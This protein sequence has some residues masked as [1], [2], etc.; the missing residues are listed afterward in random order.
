VNMDTMAPA[1][2]FSVTNLAQ[3]AQ[4][5]TT[6]VGTEPLEEAVWE[7][8]NIPEGYYDVVLYLHPFHRYRPEV[9]YFFNGREITFRS[10][11]AFGDVQDN[12][13]PFLSPWTKELIRRDTAILPGTENE[14]FRLP[15]RLSPYPMADK[16]RLSPAQRIVVGSDGTLEVR[17]V[18]AEP[19]GG[20][21]SGDLYATSFDRLE[22]ISP[23]T[24]YVELVNLS[25]EDIDLSGWTI[26]TPYGHYL[27]PEDT[28][29]GRMKPSYE[30]DDGRELPTNKGLPG[31]GVP[32]EPLLKKS[33][34]T[35]PGGTINSTDLLLEDNKILLA[36]HKNA[37]IEFIKDNYPSVPD[38]D[39][40]VVEVTLAPKEQAM[41]IRSLSTKSEPMGSGEL[42]NAQQSDMRLRLVDV[43]EDILTHNPA[44][45][46]VT[47]SDPS[48]HYVDS[49]KYRTTFNNV[50]VDIPGNSVS[51]DLVVLPGY[52]GMESFERSDPTYFETEISVDNQSGRLSGNRSVPSSIRLDAQDAIVLNLDSTKNL[53]RTHIGGYVNPSQGS[54]ND[55]RHPQ[56]NLPRFVDQNSFPLK[57][58]H[59]NGWDFIGDYYEYPD[60]NPEIAQLEVYESRHIYAREA[61][62]PDTPEK[63][64]FYDMLGGFENALNVRTTAQVRYSAFL[65]R[66]GLRELIRSGYDP[67]VDD[68]LTVR[69][70][71]R[72]AVNPDGE[73]GMVDLPVGEVMVI[74]VYRFVDPGD[75][76][77]DEEPGLE[78]NPYHIVTSMIRSNRMKQPV[79][80]KLRN[81]DTAFTIDLR[82]KFNDLSQDLKSSSESEPMIEIMVVIRKSTIDHGGG[83]TAN[84]TSAMRPD[85]EGALSTVG[86]A[87]A[88]DAQGN[89]W[90]GGNYIGNLSDDNYFFRGIELFGRGRKNRDD[91]EEANQRRQL[92]A[93]TPGRDNTGYVPA[94][95]RRRLELNGSQRDELDILDNTAYVK[96]GPL[97]TVGELS[98]LFTGNRFETINTPLIPQRLE[99]ISTGVNNRSYTTYELNKRAK[100]SE[101]EF[102]IALAQ[103]E[104]L[105]QWENQYLQLFN[106]ITTADMGIRMGL[107]NINTAPREVLMALPFCP[108]AAD[109][110]LESLIDRSNFNSVCADFIL[111]GRQ[112]VGFDMQFGIHSL[113]DDDFIS[114]VS[115]IQTLADTVYDYKIR[116]VGRE[117]DSFKN[118]DD[119][120]NERFDGLNLTIENIEGDR[121]GN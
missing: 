92:L 40:R 17:I 28:V 43:Q 26:D 16:Y 109:G 31:D 104:R 22:L 95:P 53:A 18:A 5:D 82:K 3:P 66:L 10:D 108:P 2:I 91:S 117:Y 4:S 58:A 24:Q 38:I 35:D 67:D 48:G 47:L 112:P 20:P 54:E 49:F 71:G 81:G 107:I 1:F 11:F 19:I 39:D 101:P 96:N 110:K 119:I 63:V 113:N 76:D 44:E 85:L 50:M 52:R 97:A 88:P 42:L 46:Y 14:S 79:F 15:Y 37:L 74:P 70:L 68:Q 25:T 73:F 6:L 83:A 61:V 60:D 86:G 36:N 45:K 90:F 121:P 33:K 115:G 7:F 64:W 29:I 118:F 72:Q 106:M 93:G 84:I 99:D 27:I 23:W 77:L 34:L 114:R 57:D 102:Q 8:N 30:D 105:D 98:R 100:S 12:T 116:S 120:E 94:Y 87:L 9:H 62:A 103:R 89:Y 32:S 75:N 80:A 13:G 59:W 56:L 51:M 78:E 69:V 55:K 41:V 111:A 21:G 65:W